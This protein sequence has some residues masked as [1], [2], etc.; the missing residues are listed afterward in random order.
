MTGDAMHSETPVFESR[1]MSALT[2]KTI[3]LKMECFQPTGSF[4][5][6]GIGLRCR[7]CVEGGAGHLI[8]SSAGTPALRSPMRAGSWVSA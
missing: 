4:K 5:I 2:G 8:S 3:W 7:E 6:R 1:P